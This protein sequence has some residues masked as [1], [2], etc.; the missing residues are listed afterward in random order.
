[1]YYYFENIHMQNL[2]MATDAQIAALAKVYLR[3]WDNKP[4]SFEAFLSTAQ[5]AFGDCFMVPWC[6]MV[7]GIEADGYTHS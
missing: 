6:G 7:L 5:R 3:Q 4:E 2:A 1:M